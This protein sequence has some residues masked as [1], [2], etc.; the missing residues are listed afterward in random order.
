MHTLKTH[1]FVFKVGSLGD[2]IVALP[3]I[4]NI[5]SYYNKKL[6]FIT[7]KPDLGIF[8]AWQIY[9]H[10]SY[11]NSVYEFQ[12][13]LQSIIELKKYVHS[14]EG[15]KILFYFADESG[16]KRNLRNYIFFKLIGFN[17]VYG[18][19]ECTG[20]Y[21]KR[22]TDN[23]LREV[24]PEYIR[25]QNIVEKYTG[26]KTEIFPEKN[27]INFSPDFINKINQKFF[28]L[29]EPFFVLGIGGKNKIQRWDINRYIEVL[30]SYPKKLKVIILGGKAEEEY[31][32]KIE[33]LAQNK[34]VINLCGITSILESAYI[35]KKAQFYLGNDTGTAHLAGLVGCK[36]IVISSARDNPGRWMPIGSNH[37][38]IRKSPKCAG[39]WLHADNCKYNI[40][41]LNDISPKEVLE[42][43]NSIEINA[44]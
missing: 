23:S 32:H 6:Q 13:T 1:I 35:L 42:K 37:I 26:Q 28:F 19:K 21:I 14:F 15:Q 11:F 41:C 17:E 22:N 44:T 10:T 4:K 29:T 33:Q 36:C 3:A 2:S 38:I 31:A 9:K 39:C 18:W 43:L 8:P 16:L 7:N 24:L 20:E 40:M 34:E 5:F 25:L 27:F 30:N 12:F